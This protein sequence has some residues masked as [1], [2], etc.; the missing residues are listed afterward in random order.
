MNLVLES[1][2]KR[3]AMVTQSQAE[4]EMMILK[5]E[6][7]A[8][9]RQLE[10]QG[11]ALQRLALAEGLKDSMH[12]LCG[13][14]AHLNP[15]ELTKTILQMQY[16]DMLNQAAHTGKNTFIMQCHP[17]ALNDVENQVRNAILSTDKVV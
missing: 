9:T 13:K 14:D 4:K 3:D 10:G 12:N 16:I 15:E 8:K 7:L 1:Q 2:N 5:A 17:N 11:L 6:G